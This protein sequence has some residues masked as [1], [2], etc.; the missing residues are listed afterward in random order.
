MVL[1]EHNVRDDPKHLNVL[2][3][4]SDVLLHNVFA[5]EFRKRNRK[6][7]AKSGSAFYILV[8]ISIAIR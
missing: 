3:Y 1:P 8:V 4:F 6:F 7:T 5:Q 2:L